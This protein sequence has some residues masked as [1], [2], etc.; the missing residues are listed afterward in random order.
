MQTLTVHLVQVFS[1]LSSKLKAMK[2]AERL[3][4]IDNDA[5]DVLHRMIDET[6][7]EGSKSLLGHA[8]V[9]FGLSFSPDRLAMMKTM[10]FF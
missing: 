5:D 1:L 6:S 9:V 3:A 8:S 2:S 10:V 4:E 7:A